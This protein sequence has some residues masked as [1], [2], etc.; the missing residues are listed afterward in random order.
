MSEQPVYPDSPMP[1]RVDAVQQALLSFTGIA[2][3]D[4]IIMLNGARLDPSRS[5]GAYGLPV[6]SVMEQA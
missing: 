2:I 4:Q 1:Y 3:S 6:V 5:L